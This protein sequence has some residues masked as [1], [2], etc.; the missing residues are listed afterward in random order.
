MFP[1]LRQQASIVVGAGWPTVGASLI[2][3]R[4]STRGWQQP[5]ATI[6]RYQQTG[7][8]MANRKDLP[9][10][11]LICRLRLALKAAAIQAAA[12]APSIT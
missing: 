5:R 7:S 4:L 8:R 10:P 3:I 1:G 12:G 6:S 2:I 11:L 9:A